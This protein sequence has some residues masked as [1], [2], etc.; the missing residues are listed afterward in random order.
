[1]KKYLLLIA[2]LAGCNFAFTACSDDDDN[3]D[4]IDTEA[5]FSEE[6]MAAYCALN[7]LCDIDELPSNWQTYTA[8]PTYGYAI[9]ASNPYVRTVY[10]GD[11]IEAEDCFRSLGGT[12]ESGQASATFTAGNISYVYT[13][14]NQSDLLATIDCT[15]PKFPLSRKSALCPAKCKKK[16]ASLD[17]RGRKASRA[18]ISTT[19]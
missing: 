14:K 11:I 8:E 1:M 2:L 10:I 15:C 19:P 12:I 7:E 17:I 16:T 5:A 18:M 3:A 13:A 4:E 6:A 9:D